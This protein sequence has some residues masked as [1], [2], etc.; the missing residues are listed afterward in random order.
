MMTSTVS[1]CSARTAVAAP[2]ARRPEYGSRCR[3]V[4]GWRVLRDFEQ[5][6]LDAQ[7]GVLQTEIERGAVLH[8]HTPDRFA[9]GHGDGQ[10]QGQPGLTHFWRARE[11]VQTLRDER[12]HHEVGRME[13]QAHQ[14]RAVDGT[15]FFLLHFFDLLKKV[16]VGTTPAAVD[17][18]LLLALCREKY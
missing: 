6:V 13:R 18:T 5:P 9:L 14:C 8:V 4:A 12:V 3:S 2:P 15:Q 10:P 17:L 1:G 16:R 11:D 7:L